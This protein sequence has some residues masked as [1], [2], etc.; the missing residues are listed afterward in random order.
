MDASEPNLPKS[1]KLFANEQ[2]G[3]S[4]TPQ[5]FQEWLVLR[6]GD[7]LHKVQWSVSGRQGLV[8]CTLA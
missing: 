6:I 8:A 4:V 3:S 1:D 5:A 2:P 7:S